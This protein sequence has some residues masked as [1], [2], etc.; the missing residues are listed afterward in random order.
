L[1]LKNMRKRKDKQLIISSMEGD[2]SA[3]M[4]VE[5]IRYITPA[6]SLNR[7]N[8]E[9]RIDNL[10]INLTSKSSKIDVNTRY[11]SSFLMEEKSLWYRRGNFVLSSHW[12]DLSYS[13]LKDYI[14]EEEEQVNHFLHLYSTKLSGYMNEFVYNNKLNNLFIAQK[15]GLG[16]P[17]TLITTKKEDL[18]AFYT[19]N[20][21]R[22]INKPIHHGHLSLIDK[23]DN[24][25]YSSRGTYIVE[26]E[27]IDV[28]ADS[29]GLSL[30]QG[31]IEKEVELRIFQLEDK[32]YSMAIFSQ[33]DEQTKVD[34][35]NYN[36]NKP[37]R[38]VP[39]Q[40]PMNIEKKILK[41]VKTL[42]FDTCSIDMILDTKG[43]YV[44]LEINP[45]GQ[46]G[47]VSKHCNYYLEEK[48]AESCLK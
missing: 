41:L 16:I 48:I 10:S 47:W 2:A 6:I 27:Q 29:F 25:K 1:G 8:S 12:N 11:S 35:R 15:V 14:G 45:N 20:N 30:F 5:Y 33:N 37:N 22:I 34:F 17:D 28:L 21:G 23:E 36:Y 18:L 39:F 3:D 7:Y 40:L 19:K 46:F 13:K 9:N 32:L 26:K 4:V 42:G 43:N 44:F 38:N 24:V 31:L